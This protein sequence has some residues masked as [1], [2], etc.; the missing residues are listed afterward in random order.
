MNKQVI[1]F[2][3][4]F[5]L[6]LVLSVYYVVVPSNE[7]QTVN[8]TINNN[9]EL[10]VQDAPSLFFQT[11]IEN[12]NSRHEEVKNAQ[13]EI[14][15]SSEYTN[16]EK[17]EARTK[18]TNEELIENTELGLENSIVELNFNE[19]FVEK[20][21]DYFYVTVYDGSFNDDNDV[22]NVI[23]IIDNFNE[24]FTLNN[25]SEMSL[26]QPVVNFVTF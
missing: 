8:G 17:I 18:L 22:L 26:C 23:K 11:L 13:L 7:N 10:N 6:V 4:L 15:V 19:T 21:D 24:Y 1:S 25:L 16:E 14:L 12:R 3:S 5:S 20:L 9:E 2:L